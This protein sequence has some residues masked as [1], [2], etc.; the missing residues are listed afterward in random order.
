MWIF[1]C[2]KII[3]GYGFFVSSVV[4]IFQ[5]YSLPLS[6]VNCVIEKRKGEKSENMKLVLD[7]AKQYSE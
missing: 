2:G 6:L 7:I 5:G 4:Y 3:S 1:D